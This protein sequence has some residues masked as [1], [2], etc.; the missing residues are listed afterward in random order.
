[1]KKIIF[2]NPYIEQWY[3]KNV[4]NFV[5]RRHNVYKYWYIL[6][7]IIKKYHSNVYIYLDL[8]EKSFYL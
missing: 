6:E 7:N 2:Y 4:F 8:K 1:M 3:G 5:T